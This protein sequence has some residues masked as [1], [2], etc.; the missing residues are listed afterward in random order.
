VT[1]SSTILADIAADNR[2]GSAAI[3][4]KALAYLRSVADESRDAPFDN[5][6]EHIVDSAR[7]LVEAQPDMAQLYNLASAV[8]ASVRSHSSLSGDSSA[9]V[10]KVLDEYARDEELAVERAVALAGRLISEGQTILTISN[11]SLVRETILRHPKRTS[12]TVVIPESRPMS[13]GVLLAQSL[14]SQGIRTILTTDFAATTYVKN[15][16]V[17]VCGA[18]AVSKDHVVNKVGTGVLADLAKQLNKKTVAVFTSSKII[19]DDLRKPS[20]RHRPGEEITTIRLCTGNVENIY[21]ELCPLI[22]FTHLVSDRNIYTA[23]MLKAEISKQ[24]PLTLQ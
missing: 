20:P 5:Q 13:E 19:R 8:I 11:S 21:F 16:D 7:K 24:P 14:D 6:R 12:L 22:S 10:R 4:R 1:S 17:F 15:S 23:D 18:D 2:S 9:V 3:L